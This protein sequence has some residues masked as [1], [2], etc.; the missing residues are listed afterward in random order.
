[1][2]VGVG[3]NC[4]AFTTSMLGLLVQGMF[5]ISQPWRLALHTSVIEAASPLVV[6]D[7]FQQT[8]FAL[9]YDWVLLVL[10]VQTLLSLELG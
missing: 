8:W 5:S 4:A 7:L 2:G 3:L 9:D 1:M 6:P 10:N